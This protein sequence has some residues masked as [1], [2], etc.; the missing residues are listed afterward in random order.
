MYK[1]LV[2]CHDTR[3][4][5]EIESY[6]HGSHRTVISAED[7]L[8]AGII[9]NTIK[10]NFF[11]VVTADCYDNVC[12]IKELK[13]SC[14][15]RFTPVAGLN[16]TNK[17]NEE[18]R[19]LS[20]CYHIKLP[21]GKNSFNKI[22]D[23]INHDLNLCSSLNDSKSFIILNNAGGFMRIKTDS[24]LFFE[25]SGH[26]CIIYTSDGAYNLPFAL[27]EIETY[28]SGTPLYRCHRSY[29]INTENI[30]KIDKSMAAWE[31]YFYGC[32]K[33][34]LVSRGN[35]REFSNILVSRGNMV[36]L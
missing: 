20:L 6:I 9:S 29:I 11:I 26:G 2:V 13:N 1:I 3:I 5:N 30:L 28:I 27:K 31:I 34:A 21:L 22:N 32:Q 25:S 7:T 10:I 33:T 35:K 14:L 17:L 19:E 4:R 36:S 8:Q 15:Y 18:L 12:M 23:I 16:Y 24:I